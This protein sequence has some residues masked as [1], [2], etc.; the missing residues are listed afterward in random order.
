ME[1]TEARRLNPR[2]VMGFAGP[3]LVIPDPLNYWIPRVGAEGVEE[4]LGILPHFA[5]SGDPDKE[6]EARVLENYGM[7]GAPF[8]GFTT[9]DY[10]VPSQTDQEL[11]LVLRYE[12]DPPLHAVMVLIDSTREPPPKQEMH[13]MIIYD[14]AWVRFYPSGN[15]YR[16]D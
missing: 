10:I 3:C 8:E 5:V 14:H 4:M 7:A 9:E 2:N 1:K 13:A 12:G 11:P 16:M 6:L 15:T